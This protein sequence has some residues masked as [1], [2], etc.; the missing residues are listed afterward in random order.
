MQTG[1]HPWGTEVN[2]RKL[3]H[4]PSE[5]TKRQEELKMVFWVWSG[6]V[7]AWKEQ[8][9]FSWPC[10]P[11]PENSQGLR[12]LIVSK[13][14]QA[15]WK[16]CC[17]DHPSWGVWGRESHSWAPRHGAPALGS[18][19][20]APARGR[21]T[22][23]WVQDRIREKSS[24][25]SCSLYR[26]EQNCGGGLLFVHQDDRMGLGKFIIQQTGPSQFPSKGTV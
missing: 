21:E 16:S 26:G 24:L 13:R 10:E 20:P 2:S 12:I 15:V 23:W 9:L 1:I 7:T 19:Y 18:F 17:E 5:L 6:F 11:G 4:S 8:T 3:C 22:G 25:P 14:G